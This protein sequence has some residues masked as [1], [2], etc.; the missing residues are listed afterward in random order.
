M[1]PFK[2][3]IDISSENGKI[4]EFF[5]FTND[6]H[7]TTGCDSTGCDIFNF[8]KRFEEALF[9]LKNDHQRIVFI[10]QCMKY[11]NA[12]NSMLQL[13]SKK[14]NMKAVVED[15]KEKNLEEL[16]VVQIKS[17]MPSFDEK[18]SMY[19]ENIV[20]LADII[21]EVHDNNF[22]CKFDY[23]DVRMFSEELHSY[24][25]S[26]RRSPRLVKNFFLGLCEKY[27]QEFNNCFL[28]ARDKK[29]FQLYKKK[30][31]LSTR[32]LQLL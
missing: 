14:E 8:L 31:W 17:T 19:L 24:V 15:F 22:I 9:D 26:K 28:V 18:V 4:H 20:E 7:K 27:P 21:N 6:V 13:K 16:T 1:D 23:C 25:H 32:K 12:F 29:L 2:N 10:N 11:P 3:L 30:K 5:E